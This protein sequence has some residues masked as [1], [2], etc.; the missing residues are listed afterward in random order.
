MELLPDDDPNCHCGAPLIQVP[1][2]DIVYC[3]Y[4]EEPYDSVRYNEC[5]E[6]SRQDEYS[7]SQYYFH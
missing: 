3:D 1:E 2:D 6:T 5:C 7:A 4:C